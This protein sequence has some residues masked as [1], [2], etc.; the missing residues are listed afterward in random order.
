MILDL[1]K[2]NLGAPCVMW[3][4]IKSDHLDLLTML[5]RNGTVVIYIYF[6]MCL[7]GIHSDNLTSKTYFNFGQQYNHN[8][9]LHFLVALIL[10][11]NHS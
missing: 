6:S 11:I 2:A 3:P 7:R 4:I 8:D 5:R 1:Q 9:E 10:A